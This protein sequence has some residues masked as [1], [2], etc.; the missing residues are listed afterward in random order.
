[1]LHIFNYFANFAEKHFTNYQRHT[2]KCVLSF[3]RNLHASF[4]KATHQ[5]KWWVWS[6]KTGWIWFCV[7]STSEGTASFFTEHMALDS[8]F[9]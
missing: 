7:T 4:L 3:L 6:A 5:A 8:E 9:C 1:M 2:V